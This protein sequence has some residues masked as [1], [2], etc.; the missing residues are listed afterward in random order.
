MAAP[1]TTSTLQAL[2]RSLFEPVHDHDCVTGLFVAGGG[3]RTLTTY[4]L[5]N[6]ATLKATFGAIYGTTLFVYVNPD[7]L[8]EMTSDSYHELMLR[9]LVAAAKEKEIACEPAVGE[10]SLEKLKHCVGLLTS[11]D[12][13]IVFIL[14]DFEITLSFPTSIY[15]NLESIMTVDK[16]H[17][18]YMFLSCTDLLHEELLDRLRNL[19]YAVTQHVV[20]HPLLS[21][22]DSIYVISSY[23]QRLKFTLTDGIK[24]VLF[25][26]C[27]GH[28]Q[29]LKYALH[30]AADFLKKGKKDNEALRTFLITH[31]QLRI[32]C[33]DIWQS[34]WEAEKQ[35]LL[36]VVKTKKV[37]PSLERHATYLRHMKLI[38]EAKIGA[39]VGIPVAILAYYIEAQIPKEKLVYDQTTKQLFL[40]TRSC[41][42]V[43]TPQE[44]KF[45]IHLLTKDGQ[46]VT[47]DEV[48]D[49]MWG[50]ASFD[51]YSD[52]TIDKITSTIRKKLTQIG[53][54]SEKLVTLKKRGFSFSQ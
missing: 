27:G 30:H 9:V 47:R 46:V 38:T 20:Y 6:T 4:F 48:A 2:H 1:L 37:P 26:V 22:Q 45:L 23:N 15:L 19:K 33:S 34:L 5:H 52:Y 36:A 7:D 39:E 10:N 14:N 40:G 32:I 51:K 16:S 21:V 35:V 43:F 3:K 29:L 13:F 53:F 42:G 31:P 8:T 50:S 11:R 41:G 54:P 17:V 24:A 25:D 12:W 44:Y 49:V 18:T 28:P